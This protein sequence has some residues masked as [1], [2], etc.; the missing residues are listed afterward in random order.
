[1]NKIKFI[2]LIILFSFCYH[3][4]VFG[5]KPCS[6]SPCINY[7]TN[8][9]DEEKCK[10]AADWIA[11][12]KIENI[13]HDFKKHPLNKDFTKF[14]V[15]IK[16]WE[17]GGD[18]S[19]KILKLE[20]EWCDPNIPE[21]ISGLF[22]FYG[23]GPLNKGKEDIYSY[24]HWEKITKFKEGTIKKYLK[25]SEIFVHRVLS[26]IFSNLNTEV[27]LKYTE[28]RFKN[29]KKDLDYF[30]E[31]CKERFGKFE[32]INELHIDRQKISTLYN[33]IEVSYSTVVEF[34][35]ERVKILI[36]VERRDNRWTIEYFNAESDLIVRENRKELDAF[37]YA[38]IPEIF[39]NLDTEAFLKYAD[40]RFK[41]DREKLDR[42]FNICK[43][44]FGKLERV[45][46]YRM[47][48]GITSSLGG[49]ILEAYYDSDIEFDKKIATI[50]VEIKKLAGK[51]IIVDLGIISDD[52]GIVEGLLT[53]E[54]ELIGFLQ[55][56]SPHEASI[57]VENF[58][59]GSISIRQGAFKRNL[60]EYNG[61]TVQVKGYLDYM[62]SRESYHPR[63]FYS[64]TKID[65]I[66]IIQ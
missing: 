33:D 44:R 4:K 21:N 22:R 36:R 3:Y 49:Y 27:F 31:L 47:G 43:E 66:E 11:M 1:M 63:A 7:R 57:Y 60:E 51:W 23:K 17:K 28:E 48:T 42:F 10:K 59:R 15:R 12:G 30:F 34:E 65:S 58:P 9:F 14:S 56:W 61:K 16:K 18:N 35:K 52:R 39:S 37:V 5:T 62:V 41:N 8:E 26:D 24:F 54:V 64:L 50:S 13:V 19:I 6:G 40:E 45:N 29:Y 2:L 46:R 32:N 55:Y 38:V 25:E 53:G 20:T